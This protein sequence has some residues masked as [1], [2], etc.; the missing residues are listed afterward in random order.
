VAD[1]TL[2]VQRTEAKNA[3]GSTPLHWACFNGHK[4]VVQELLDKGATPTMLNK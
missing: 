4:E 1:D 2:W 3:Q